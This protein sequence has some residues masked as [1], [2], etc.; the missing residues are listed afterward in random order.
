QINEFQ[1][2]ILYHPGKLNVRADM[3]SRIAAIE[4]STPTPV[5]VPADIPDVWV[6]DRIDLQDLARHQKEQFHDAYVEA[7]QETDESPYI[8]QEARPIP[9]VEESYLPTRM[10]RGPDRA[11][12]DHPN[13]MPSITTPPTSAAIAPSFVFL[14][15]DWSSWLVVLTSGQTISPIQNGA[16]IANEETVMEISGYADIFVQLSDDHLTDNQWHNVCKKLESQYNIHRFHQPGNSTKRPRHVAVERELYHLD[17][18]LHKRIRDIRA[19]IFKTNPARHR[20]GLFDFV[21]EIASTLFGVPT[22]RD[23]H[24]LTQ[25]NERLADA[26][27]GVVEHNRQVTAKINVIGRAQLEIS[28]KINEVIRYQATRYSALEGVY[29]DMRYMLYQILQAMK[30]NT[31][32][33]VITENLRDFEETQ[34]LVQAMRISCESRT[35]TEQLIPLEVIARILSSNLNHR[36]IDPISYYGYI[37]VHKIT[38]IAGQVSNDQPYHCITPK[39]ADNTLVPPT[40]VLPNIHGDPYFTC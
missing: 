11:R 36:K 16:I 22:A 25:A 32:L 7:S 6:T 18:L 38:E 13:L 5:I 4:P 20:R 26:V 21:G 40:E 23:L 14:S 35:I 27:E 33:D 39:M 12:N 30:F 15:D 31:L 29:F 2:P 3:L 8:V 9:V 10:P 34:A 17:T 37:Q 19:R 1:A 24:S 28:K